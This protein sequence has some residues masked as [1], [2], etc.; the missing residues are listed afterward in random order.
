M[1][2]DKAKHPEVTK[3]IVPCNGPFHSR[4]HTGFALNEGFHDVKYGR[5]TALLGK[6]KVPKH[7]PNFEGDSYKHCTT[8]I[9]DDYVGTLAYF[10]L[11]VQ[12]PPPELLLDDPAAYVAQIKSA[13]G[14]A[15]FESMRYAG[16]PMAHYHLAARKEDGDKNCELE[17]YAFHV[18]RALAHKPVEARVLLISLISSQASHPKVAEV[19]KQTAFFSWFGRP[20]G[21]ID[22]DRAMENI[23]L[24]QDKRRG[25]F[26]DFERSLEFTPCLTAFAHV[27]EALSLAD[28]GESA[29]CDPLRESTINA[30]TVICKDLVQRLGTDLTIEDEANRIFHTGG[31]P[32]TVR[33]TDCLSH[34][35]WEFIWRVAEGTSLGSGRGGRPESANVFID[36]F[37]HEHLWT[38]NVL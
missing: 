9:R 28:D 16:I 15:A 33:S 18:C 5:S 32:K 6:D 29:A 22:G 21:S 3:K 7:I 12:Q 23:N 37:L 2:R 4:G 35:P 30:A 1:A 10:L 20:G 14:L 17:A 27:R 26:S 38:A 34:R 8:H 24:L 31:A 13:G 11:H 36:R 25:R 19:V